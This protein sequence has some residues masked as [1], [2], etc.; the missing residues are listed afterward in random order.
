MTPG[1]ET[2][3]AKYAADSERKVKAVI[4]EGESFWNTMDEFER[5]SVQS[6]TDRNICFQI[7]DHLH[8][9]APASRDIK[10]AI[11]LIDQALQR[12]GLPDDM[13]L[14]RGV[15]PDVWELMKADPKCVTPGEE[16]TLRGFTSTTYD[17]A[18]AWK[19]ASERAKD[20]DEIAMIEV[21]ASKGTR[22]LSL[23]AHSYSPNDKE[24][25]INRNTNFKVIEACKVGNVMRL[26]WEVL[27]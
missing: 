20:A 27:P 23:E 6:Y 13:V 1:G 17:R 3:K 18:R 21:L 7:N 25:L 12:A 10:D 19:Y 26:I 4:E 22:A 8:N 5:V 14:C 16:F 2:A 11:E 9:G 15:N 24:I